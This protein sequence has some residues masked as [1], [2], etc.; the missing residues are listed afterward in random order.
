[1]KYSSTFFEVYLLVNLKKPGRFR[2]ICLPF[3]EFRN[4]TDVKNEL[5]TQIVGNCGG[6]VIVICSSKYQSKM[7][8][9]RYQGR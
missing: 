6:Y 5:T 3:L 1:M 2:Q 7:K 8:L 4:F 9:E